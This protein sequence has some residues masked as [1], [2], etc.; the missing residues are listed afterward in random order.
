[1]DFFRDGTPRAYT[2]TCRVWFHSI[3]CI[4]H[5]VHEPSLCNIRLL[6]WQEVH[7]IDK[8]CW[9]TEGVDTS[10]NVEREEVEDD[11]FEQVAIDLWVYCRIYYLANNEIFQRYI[12]KPM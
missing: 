2:H 10:Q 8:V 5:H 7:E 9:N 3:P 11:G 12:S 4:L 1:M 6:W